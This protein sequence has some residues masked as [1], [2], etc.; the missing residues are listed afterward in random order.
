MQG[1]QQSLIDLVRADQP[2]D[3]ARDIAAAADAARDRHNDA[4]LAVLHYGSSRRGGTAG[5]AMVDLYLLVD[6][7]RRAHGGRLS[8]WLNRLL[9]PNVYYLEIPF[10]GRVVAVK[11]AV[12]SMDQLARRVGRGAL[13]PYFWARFSQPTAIAW[14][15][16]HEARAAVEQALATAVE[17]MLAAS[18]ALID[19][20]PEPA[21]WWRRAF[22]ETYRTELRAE[23]D[24][25]AA[26]IVAADR[27]RYR[28]AADAVL[29]I[30]PDLGRA[31]GGSARLRWWLRRA[32]GKPLSV[33]RLVKAAYTFAGGADYLVGKIRRHSGEEI[34]L[35]PWQRRHPVIAGL[36]YL[37]RLV[38]RG[39][40]R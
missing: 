15:R 36:A 34:V 28:R 23:R 1:A 19:A 38:V 26:E 37:W 4:V 9:P 12:V 27:A 20:P 16:D 31:G 8:A 22:A 5:G 2:A 21:G 13:H 17:T 39:A 33:L 29:A 10:E 14:T 3:I 24:N 40:V 30:H 6:D 11:Y 35:T 18:A 32:I 7:Y 25:R